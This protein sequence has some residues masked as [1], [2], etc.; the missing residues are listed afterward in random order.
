MSLEKHHLKPKAPDW[1][2]IK[3]RTEYMQMHME[4]QRQHRTVGDS[5]REDI[6]TRMQTEMTAHEV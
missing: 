4:T 3:D 2:F 5:A 6:S 1:G